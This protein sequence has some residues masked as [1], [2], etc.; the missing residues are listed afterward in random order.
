MQLPPSEYKGGG[1]VKVLMLD[2]C[3]ARL[4]RKESTISHLD[5]NRIYRLPVWFAKVLYS[6]GK[7][8]IIE[9]GW[10]KTWATSN[11]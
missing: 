11:K 5:R 6:L 9:E 10:K 2:N 1:S 7:A 8:E 4:K 3:S